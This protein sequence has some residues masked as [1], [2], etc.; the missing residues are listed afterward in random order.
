MGR[1]L[2]CRSCSGTVLAAPGA[3]HGSCVFCE[4][5]VLREVET[6]LELAAGRA[7]PLRLDLAAAEAVIQDYWAG[8][9]ERGGLREAV[10]MRQLW[11]PAW[12]LEG[13]FEY[14]YAGCVAPE[15]GPIWTPHTGT[16]EERVS[17]RLVAASRSL[18]R[19]EFVALGDFVLGELEDWEGLPA[20]GMVELGGL[21]LEQAR[22]AVERMFCSEVAARLGQ[23][24]VWS[25]L[26]V[27]GV[28]RQ[29]QGERVLVPV[30]VCTGVV[31]DRTY[32]AVINGQTG[33]ITGGR[34]F[35]SAL[36]GGLLPL[37][38]V[39]VLLIFLSAVGL[40]LAWLVFLG[41]RV[42]VAAPIH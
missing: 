34:P 35:A 1:A 40:F 37:A 36:P 39:G 30:Y 20:G 31:G 17:G 5:G 29:L 8:A 3:S 13:A 23:E 38:V 25:T 4:A 21:S 22:P 2:V 24:R 12:V 19:V 33:T 32:R 6:S 28:L 9:D 11:V 41:Y 7:L 10:V 18:H 15:A 42:N 26:K 27:S 16:L 14:A